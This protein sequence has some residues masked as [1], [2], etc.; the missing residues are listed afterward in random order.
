[1]QTRSFTP[2]PPRSLA[3][4][5]PDHWADATF[6][7]A[8]LGDARRTRRLVHTAAALAR[9]PTAT[10]PQQLSSP[11]ALKGAYR[12]LDTDAVDEAAVLAP[13]LAQTRAAAGDRSVVLLVQDTTTLAFP[14]HPATTGLGPI[15]AG[16]GHGFHLQTVLA[17]QP[18]PRQVLGVLAAEPWLRQ[19]AP[20]GA[21]SCSQR[22]GRRRESDIWPRMVH[23][24]GSPPDQTRWVHVADRGAD[25]FGLF[26]ACQETRTDLLVRAAQ[27]RIVTDADGQDQLL[28]DVVADAPA[29]G[30]RP[31]RLPARHGH[32]ARE[33]ELA[34]RWAAVTIQV[35]I[36]WHEPA[37]PV[38]MWAVHVEEVGPV[39]AESDPIAWT[40]L[41][42]VPVDTDEEAWERVDW[43]TARWTIEEF[44]QCLKSG[45][46]AETTQLRDRDRLW[47]HVAMLL[48]LAVRLLHLR[49][50]ARQH[51]QA[52]VATEADQLTVALVAART[53]Q[54][55]ATTVGAF[56]RQVARLGGHQGR[57]RD[58]PPG[59][60]TLWRG[61]FVLQTL[62]EG[63]RLAA[64]LT[65]T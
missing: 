11:A 48:P 27:N 35:P 58:G 33:T 34:I 63:A 4:A 43:Y 18:S 32:P 64:H 17:M 53:G 9:Q 57:T 52:P 25:M 16:S 45:C 8:D 47:R 26:T 44:H 14:T 28:F 50:L 5:S 21:E 10:L 59:W 61:W 42:T 36:H 40:L 51:P 13:H 38:P 65:E 24:V 3:T 12:L 62:V 19:P 1:M 22:R 6:G 60:K 31:L 56:A 2:F 54:P 29:P 30:R 49:D 41:T 23:T 20:E 37:E 46:Q 7:T 55:P 15:S 39:P